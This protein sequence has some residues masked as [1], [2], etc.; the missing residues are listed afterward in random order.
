[1]KTFLY[2]LTFFLSINIL[3]SQK[4][5]AQENNQAY[6]K[7]NQGH[8][9]VVTDF[10]LSANNKYLATCSE[11]KTIILWDFETQ[12][13]IKTIKGHK[14]I[15]SCIDINSKNTQIVTGE[16]GKDDNGKYTVK[17]WDIATGNEVR[18]IKPNARRIRT[19]KFSNDGKFLFVGAQDRIVKYDLETGNKVIDY[20]GFKFQL[21]DVKIS[22]D[23]KFITAYNEKIIIIWDVN[24]REPI[25]TIENKEAEF[26]ALS[27]DKKGNNIITGNTDN[28][29]R[30]YNSMSGDESKKYTLFRYPIFTLAVDNANKIIAASDTKSELTVLMLIKVE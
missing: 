7:A 5:N 11:D 26:S 13:E 4:V 1:M 15:I 12:K 10:V 14:N 23:F 28:T 20:T 21:I 22:K 19:V 29:I 17:I 3:L 6:L 27:I 25:K 8:T 24:S 16:A 18:T 9:D 30:I 2:T